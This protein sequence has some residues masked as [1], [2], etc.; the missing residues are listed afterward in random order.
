[1]IGQR[2]RDSFER[3]Y[4]KV[5][6]WF[7]SAVEMLPNF[8]VAVIILIIFYFLAGYI[9]RFVKRQVSESR[10][11][12]TLTTLL[13]TTS[14]LV[15]IIL[16]TIIALE[17]LKLGTAVTS[18]LAGAGIIGLALAFAFQDIVSNYVS[19]IIMALR[20]VFHVGDLIKTN[21]FYG[22]VKRV[23]LRTTTL[24]LMP[25]QTVRIPNSQILQSPLINYTERGVRRVDLGLGV[26][27]DTDLR[28]AI[29]ASRDAI[30]EIEY[31][32]S[33]GIEVYFEEFNNSSIDFVIRFWISFENRHKDYKKAMSDAIL[34]VKEEF[35][36]RGLDIPFPI[37]TLDVDDDIL[38][39]L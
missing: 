28:E 19:G 32:D 18:M 1:M 9:R 6:G 39:K 20:D 12:D 17:V 16:G 14:Y 8:L 22:T 24:D 36:E 13:A 15:V 29:D 7:D 37:R 31:K 34:A 27:Y 2:L 33:K 3:V 35:D 26:S 25:G 23:G 38:D 30:E 5:W 10:L 4:D 21:D 11:K